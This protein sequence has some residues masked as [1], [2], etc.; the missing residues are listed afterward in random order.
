ML[1]AER[2]SVF[3]LA[4]HWAGFLLSLICSRVCDMVWKGMQPLCGGALSSGGTPSAL[5]CT[6]SL[7]SLPLDQVRVSPRG[8]IGI[9]TAVHSV[10]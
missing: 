8:I 2:M 7:P 4:L 9:L 3:V 6:A 1:Y 5:T 10:C